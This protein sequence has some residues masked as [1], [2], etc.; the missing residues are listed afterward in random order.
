MKLQFKPLIVNSA[1]TIIVALSSCQKEN[2]NT[3]ASLSSTSNTALAIQ[4]AAVSTAS[5][6]VTAGIVTR[7]DSIYAFRTCGPSEHRDSIAFND[8]PAAVLSYLSTNYSGYTNLKSYSI[9]NSSGDI[10]GYIAAILFNGN[11]VAIKFDENGVFLEVLE[12]REGRDLL[13]QDGYHQGGCFQNRNGM[14]Q[15]TLAISALPASITS[16]FS[17]N[18]PQDTLLKALKTFSGKYVV[19]SKD[20][21]LYATIFDSIGTFITRE[22]LPTKSGRI[23]SIDQNNLPATILNYLTS[24]Y[25][26]YVIDNSFSITRNGILQGYFVVIDANNTKYGIEFD[27]AGNFVKVKSII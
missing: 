17:T 26:G 10:T 3:P 8:L 15:D 24:T 21:N 4:S 25:P 1:I 2:S 18:Y 14:H 22:Q 19:L 11:P 6:A 7:G 5:F 16:Y 23:N 12:L 9:S 13:S 20:I 27:S